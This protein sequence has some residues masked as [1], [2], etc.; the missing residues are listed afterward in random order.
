M[1]IE[2]PTYDIEGAG[3]DARGMLLDATSLIVSV[4]RLA[5]T[6]PD[7]TLPVPLNKMG[8][9]PSPSSSTE[10]GSPS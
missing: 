9:P 7:P 5:E 10:R 8:L 6:E 2:T 3:Y 4:R 1:K